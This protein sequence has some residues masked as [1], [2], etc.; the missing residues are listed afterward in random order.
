[1][2]TIIMTGLSLLVIYLAVSVII[3]FVYHA[4]CQ[5]PGKQPKGKSSTAHPQ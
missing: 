2:G 3:R 5:L 4:V 1:M